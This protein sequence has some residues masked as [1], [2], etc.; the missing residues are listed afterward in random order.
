MK[1]EDI[2]YDAVLADLEAQRDAID[3]AIFGIRVMLKARRRGI[4]GS[5][6]EA[7]GPIPPDAFSEM[8]VSAAILKYL[9]MDRKPRSNSEIAE[10]LKSGGIK[11][12]SATFPSTV[13]T[14]LGRLLKKGG[15][16]K[17]KRKWTLKERKAG[18][19]AKEG[20]EQKHKEPHGDPEAAGKGG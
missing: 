11:T 7:A 16:S 4:A 2:D 3:K 17:R 8:T 18:A 13:S 20:E 15:V 1:H 14:A 5:S 10:A 9:S 19:G 6:E 12:E